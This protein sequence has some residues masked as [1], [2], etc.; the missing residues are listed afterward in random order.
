MTKH[1]IYFLAH[2]SVSFVTCQKCARA[3]ARGAYY[4]KRALITA[5]RMHISLTFGGAGGAASKQQH[6]ISHW[7]MQAAGVG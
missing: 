3:S 6:T 2:R 7:G 4:Q 5:S 1:I